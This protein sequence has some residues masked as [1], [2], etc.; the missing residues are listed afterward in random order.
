VAKVDVFLP[1]AKLSRHS[2][3]AFVAIPQLKVVL[4]NAYFDLQADV[5][6]A[7]RIGVSFH[8]D[9]AVGLHRHKD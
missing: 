8:A 7:D 9:D 1:T 4:M 2:L 6:A 5:L 3:E